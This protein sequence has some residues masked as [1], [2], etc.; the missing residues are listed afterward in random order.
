MQK[1]N[2][3]I[4]DGVVL[5]TDVV[6]FIFKK[7]EPYSVFVPFLINKVLAISF[8]T[9]AELYHGIYKDHW[10]ETKTA[11]LQ[12]LLHHYILLPFDQGLCLEWANIK[13]DCESSGYQIEDSDCW[14][15]ACAKYYN[16]ALA[17]NNA[18]HFIHVKGLKL[19]GP[20]S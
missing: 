13:S 9:M 12:N 6:S 1:I 5:D 14:I 16:C 10:G 4:Q 3:I 11:S 19:I 2:N 8:I 15:A 7:K 20:V 18:R 17:T